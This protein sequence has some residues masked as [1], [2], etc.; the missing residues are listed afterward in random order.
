MELIEGDRILCI[1]EWGRPISPAQPW[2]EIIRFSVQNLLAT[3]ATK[4][5]LWSM[6]RPMLLEYGAKII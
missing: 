3:Y 4:P 2:L 6:S 5:L 1:G